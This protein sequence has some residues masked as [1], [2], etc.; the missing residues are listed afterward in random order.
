VQHSVE[1]KITRKTAREFKSTPECD[2]LARSLDGLFRVP[3][4]P[5]RK[6]TNGEGATPRVVSA[7]AKRVPTVTIYVIERNSPLGVLQAGLD[8]VLEKQGRPRRMVGLKQKVGI[9]PR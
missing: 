8:V 6:G 9:A 3:A 2:G 7:E 5:Q 1:E 4:E